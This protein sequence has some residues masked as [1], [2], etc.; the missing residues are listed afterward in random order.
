MKGGEV[1]AFR[2]EPGYVANFADLSGQVKIAV[3]SA[4][5]GLGH[6]MCFYGVG[7][8]GG[9]P[10]KA[11]IEWI[12]ANRSFD[13]HEL[14]FSTPAGLHG[15]ISPEHRARLP[16]VATELQHT[17]PGCYSVMHDIKRAQ[18]RGEELLDQAERAAEAF[19]ASDG[20]RRSTGRGSTRP[21][22]IS[23]SPS[24]MTS[25]PAPRYRPPGTRCAPCRDAPASSAR[26]SFR[27]DAALVVP[28][29]AAGQRASGRRRQ[30]RRKPVQRLRRG[31]ALS[32]LRRL[33]RALAC[34]RSAGGRF[35]SRRSSP[36]PTS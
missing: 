5:P 33:A 3:E 25:S 30:H 19:A 17:F 14:I 29:A 21:G 11:M 10:S 22:T 12:I 4:D 8:H 16:R 27:G 18:R 1:T 28:R 36:I 13:G 31:R 26:R 7:N 15:C 9:G 34:R 6:T 35:R 2:I 32:R 20:E 23:S 24:S